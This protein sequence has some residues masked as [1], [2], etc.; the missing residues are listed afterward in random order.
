MSLLIEIMW[1][2]PVSPVINHLTIPETESVLIEP[3]TR[4]LYPHYCSLPL[5]PFCLGLRPLARY[6]VTK[7]ANELYFSH[8]SPREIGSRSS[9]LAFSSG[10]SVNSCSTTN[11]SL[12]KT[13][14]EHCVQP[15]EIGSRPSPLVFSSGVR[16][17]SCS[18]TNSCPSMTYIEHCVQPREI[19]SRSSPQA[20][21]SG[22]SVISCSTT[23]SCPGMTYIEQCSAT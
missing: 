22:I 15:R 20:L 6:Y 7:D 18:T 2:R 3:V 8:E 9:P 10:V 11:L 16:V 5:G 13:Y 19:G 17:I 14:I 12:G 23:N 21:T 4:L 1:D